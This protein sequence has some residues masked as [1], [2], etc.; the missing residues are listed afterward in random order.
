MKACDKTNVDRN[1]IPKASKNSFQNP[2]SAMV[3]HRPSIT[4]F[5]ANPFRT[6][7]RVAMV[8]FGA[9]P[10]FFFFIFQHLYP[11]FQMLLELCCYLR[12]FSRTP[13]DRGGLFSYFLL[14]KKTLLLDF[15][16]CTNPFPGYIGTKML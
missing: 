11:K 6:F 5:P 8:E 13:S 4:L 3:R 16:N 7:V 14:S 12:S 15:R 9:P 10:K 1:V 2:N